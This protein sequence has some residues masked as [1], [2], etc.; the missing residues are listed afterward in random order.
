MVDTGGSLENIGKLVYPP[1]QFQVP[2]RG[3]ASKIKWRATEKNI[4]H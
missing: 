1:A 4:R 2:V 3:M